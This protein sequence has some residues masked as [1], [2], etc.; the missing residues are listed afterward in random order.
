M[1]ALL[2]YK[3]SLKLKIALLIGCLAQTEAESS[4][5]KTSRFY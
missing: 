4:E 2:S 3:T 1:S 5:L